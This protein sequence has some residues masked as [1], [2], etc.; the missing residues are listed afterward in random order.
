MKDI[1]DIK[2]DLRGTTSIFD[3]ESKPILKSYVIN[4]SKIVNEETNFKIVNSNMT[5]KYSMMPSKR[6]MNMMYQYLVKENIIE[7]NMYLEP[8]MV[9]KSSK[10][11]SGV[12]VVTI[13]VNVP[14]AAVAGVTLTKPRGKLFC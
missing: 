14:L 12:I 1:E 8:Y 4:L 13:V 7:K 10:S 2:I 5:K 11:W 3:P 6:D 9:K